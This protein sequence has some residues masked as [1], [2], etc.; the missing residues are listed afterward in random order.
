MQLAKLVDPVKG[1]IPKKKS[2]QERKLSHLDSAET[3]MQQVIRVFLELSGRLTYFKL[4]KLLYLFDLEAKNRLGFAFASDIYLRQVDG[5]W[6]PSLYKAIVAMEGHEVRKYFSGKIPIVQLGPSPR[7]PI[8][9]KDEVLDIV[10]E[11]WDK[12]ASFNNSAIKVA[13]YRTREM[14]SVLEKEKDGKMMLNKPV[15]WKS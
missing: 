4:T 5:P 2:A 11:T 9:L 3:S 7:N 14:Q 8:Q 6:P 10:Y 12:Y 13:V 1:L 15:L